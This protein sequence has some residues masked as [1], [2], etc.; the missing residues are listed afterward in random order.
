MSLESTD[1]VRR[2]CGADPTKRIKRMKTMK[3]RILPSLAAIST[4]LLIGAVIAAAQP[5]RG[6]EKLINKT[7]SSDGTAE[8]ALA[9]ALAGPDG[10][11]AAHAEYAAIVQKFGEV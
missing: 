10:E 6:A 9:Q 3:Q 5:Q 4:S 2:H 8:K 1:Y 11:Y 7:A